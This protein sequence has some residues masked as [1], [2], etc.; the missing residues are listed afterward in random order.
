MLEHQV[1]LGSKLSDGC[2][3]QA[4]H[5]GFEPAKRWLRRILSAQR[6]AKREILSG[7]DAKKPDAQQ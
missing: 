6:K 2:E 3:L 7:L 4:W 1:S 5:Q